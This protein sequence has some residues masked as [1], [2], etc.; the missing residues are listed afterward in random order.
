[1]IGEEALRV[2]HRRE[3]GAVAQEAGG[4]AVLGLRGQDPGRGDIGAELRRD[5]RSGVEPRRRRRVRLGAERRH[6]LRVLRSQACQLLRAADAALDRGVVQLVDG[7][8][9]GAVAEARGDAE[10]DVGLLARGGDGVAGVADVAAMAAAEPG[11]ALV[12]L[13]EPQRLLEDRAGLAFVE[14]H[15]IFLAVLITFTPVKCAVDEPC[16]TAL[17]WLGWP[18][19]SL[20]EPPR[21]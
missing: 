5:R 7:G 19:P 15:Q 12:G 18:L 4:S 21:R 1:M 2:E 10:A 13:G 6:V 20:N 9:A 14:I 8:V 17:D 3:A 16:D 11:R